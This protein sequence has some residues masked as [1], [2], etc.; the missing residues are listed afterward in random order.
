[1]LA[2]DAFE[3]VGQRLLHALLGGGVDLVHEADQQVDQRVGDL[4]LTLPTQRAQQR[5]ADRHGRGAQVRRIQPRRAGAPSVD[6]LLRAIGKQVGRQLEPADGRKL[7]DLP[8]R[9]LQPDPSRIGLQLRQQRLTRQPNGLLVDERLE[10]R[11]APRTQPLDR[12]C[13]E[14]LLEPRPR[15]PGDPLDP[16]RRLSLQRPTPH[17]DG[18]DELI[19]TELDGHTSSASHAVNVSSSARVASRKPKTLRISTR[20]RFTG[21]AACQ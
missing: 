20:W 12:L 21:R 1:V 17:E 8:Q 9:G 10:P 11:H 4:A 3:V 7:V 16:A 15:R 5:E 13:A 2:A 6:Q 18:V 14:P 19:G